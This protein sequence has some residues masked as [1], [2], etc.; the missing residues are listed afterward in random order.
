MCTLKSKPAAAL[1]QMA[2][3]HLDQIALVQRRAISALALSAARLDHRRRHGKRELQ[4]L[5]GYRC[6][7]M[8]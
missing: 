1:R 8:A 4:A 7:S 2:A 3:G 6:N 5:F